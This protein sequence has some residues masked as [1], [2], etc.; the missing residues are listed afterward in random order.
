MKQLRIL[1]SSDDHLKRAAEELY[2]SGLFEVLKCGSGRM[3]LL[4]TILIYDPDAIVLIAGNGVSDDDRELVPAIAAIRKSNE[5]IKIF[6][7][8]KGTMK[9]DVPL[10]EGVELIKFISSRQVAEDLLLKM[11]NSDMTR[12]LSTVSRSMESIIYEIIDELG[13]TANYTG[14]H[15][16][17]DILKA[18]IN[19][20]ITANSSF[21]KCVYPMI[22]KKYNVTPSSAERSIRRAIDRSWEHIDKNSK[23]KYFGIAY[24]AGSKPGNREY[25][26]IVYDKIRRMWL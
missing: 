1:F 25:I 10:P 18:L 26:M 24:D 2:S 9:T 13:I 21:S 3:E 19:G 14:Q 5:N 20:E 4:T 6:V 16:I 17:A 15:Y 12:E 23:N 22:A 11:Y 8:V 7:T